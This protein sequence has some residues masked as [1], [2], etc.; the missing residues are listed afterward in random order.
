MKSKA[1]EIAKEVK[2]SIAG[3]ISV[4]AMFVL[5]AVVVA[6]GCHLDIFNEILEQKKRD[7][8]RDC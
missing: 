2:K 5:F 6:F 7:L 3:D 8:Y 4:V 1:V